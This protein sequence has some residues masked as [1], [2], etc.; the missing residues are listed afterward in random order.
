MKPWFVKEADIIKF[1]TPKAKV[2]ELPNVQMYPD[3]LTGVKDLHNRKAQG[4][5]SQDS[6]DRLYSD[7]INRF[8]K[9]ESFENPWFL[10]EA[11][12]NDVISDLE[13]I[14]FNDVKKISGK[15]IAVFVP[16]PDR[17][18]AMNKILSIFKGSTIDKS[19]P[20]SIGAVVHRNGTKINI[21]PAGKQGVDSA[22]LKNEQHLIQK[23]N[24]FVKQVGPLDITF[25]GDN[26]KSITANNMDDIPTKL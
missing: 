14:G 10:R 26:K 4:E 22:G 1:P 13:K 9:K 17:Q 2:V 7:L 12:I 24:Q 20:S 11:P 25:V 15:K 8:M 3:F 5:I 18:K 19:D 23:I 16:N 21:R 6:H